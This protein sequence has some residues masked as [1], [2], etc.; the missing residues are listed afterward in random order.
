MESILE[1][2][3]KDY[4]NAYCRWK[5][6]DWIPL[7]TLN[8]QM[9]I[10]QGEISV[11]SIEKYGYQ[12]LEQFHWLLLAKYTPETHIIKKY[13]DKLEVSLDTRGKLE[14]RE[15]ESHIK[16][17]WEYLS[18]NENGIRVLEK[19][20]DK[21]DWERLSTNPNALKILEDNVD[22]INWK[23]LVHNP[24]P[25]CLNLFKKYNKMKKIDFEELSS[26][27]NKES[28]DLLEKNINR[29]NWHKLS[30]NPGAIHILEENQSEI[31]WFW[32]SGNPSAIHLLERNIDKIVWPMLCSNPDLSAI[33]LLEQNPEKICWINLSINSSAVDLLEKNQDKIDWINLSR[34]QG[35]F[36]LDYDYLRERM[37]MIRKELMEKT[38]HP[39]RVEEWCL[40]GYMHDE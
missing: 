7:D 23:E 32:L 26:S 1:K 8:I 3:K 21:I 5:L 34:N 31:D 16:Q 35:I 40:H 18:E 14:R 29:V 11:N 30:K 13:I 4:M 33:C 28:I 27:S 2:Q 12:N 39:S 24:N 38:W 10:T 22:K 37:N 6:K 9:L 17:L 25:E 19:N 20:K 36:E 15:L